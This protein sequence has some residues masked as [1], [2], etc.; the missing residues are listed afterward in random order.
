LL[1]DK[2][3]CRLHRGFVGGVRC[4]SRGNSVPQ[5]PEPGI[6]GIAVFDEQ[7][8]AIAA[9]VSSLRSAIRTPSA[10]AD[11]LVA[12]PLYTAVE[13]LFRDHFSAEDERMLA[14]YYPLVNKHRA[15]HIAILNDIARTKNRF[16][17]FGYSVR[18]PAEKCESEVV[19]LVS[20]WIAEHIEGLDKPLAEFLL[21]REGTR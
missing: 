13:L 11:R 9:S 5:V 17:V 6:V 19:A 2:N 18:M 7:H 15:A 21:A 1:Q 8:A 4:F 10:P 14:S 12:M 16:L 20:S 3:A